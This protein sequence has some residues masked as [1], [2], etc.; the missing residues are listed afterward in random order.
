MYIGE[1]IKK[2]CSDDQIGYRNI[3][4]NYRL[5][6]RNNRDGFPLD[7]IMLPPISHAISARAVETKWYVSCMR[8]AVRTGSTPQRSHLLR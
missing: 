4:S 7:Y 5:I 3:S 1:G 6:T 8:T 2:R